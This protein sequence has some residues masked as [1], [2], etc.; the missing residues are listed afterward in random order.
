M[1]QD[2]PPPTCVTLHCQWMGIS[3]TLCVCVCMC[4][5]ASASVCVCMC[6]C[7]RVYV[8]A[9]MRVCACVYASLSAWIWTKIIW[10]WVFLNLKKIWRASLAWKT[11]QS[12]FLNWKRIWRAFLNWKGI[13]RAFLK[14]KQI[15]RAFLTLYNNSK[16]VQLSDLTSFLF[17]LYVYWFSGKYNYYDVCHLMKLI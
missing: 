16:L 15:W 17:H 14:S 11:T 6:A 12:A 7:E 9:C 10:T 4:V 5:C 8:C 3:C 1:C 2:T 13:W